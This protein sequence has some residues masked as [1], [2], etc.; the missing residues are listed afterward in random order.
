MP[1]VPSLRSGVTF[2]DE[3]V[4]VTGAARGIGRHVA[5]EFAA[6]A[7]DVTVLDVTR[8][9]R[10][11]SHTTVERIRDDG[12]EA[13]FVAADL[14]DEA[15][16]ETAVQ[17]AVETYGSLDVLVNNAAVNHLGRADEV[18]VDDWDETLAVNLRGTFLAARFALASLRETGGSVVNVASTV[19]LHGSP[20]YAAYGPSKAG[21]INLTRQLARDFSP[22][23]VRV[24]AVAPGVVAA[25][26]AT[27]ELD[28]PETAAY[29][30]E[31]TLL[32]RF[33]TEQDVANA[34]LFLASAAASFV[35]G[36]TLVVDGGWRA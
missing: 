7:A 3:H 6:A 26:M 9:P 28:D 13:T 18:S 34:V 24:N 29:K 1:T 30:R 21:V 2:T 36:E 27:Q 8:T 20:G 23:G 5:C 32:D 22:E 17:T 33:G 14:T 16:V 11:G 31:K 12:G 10:D 4:L 15:A 35:T 25:G 19:G